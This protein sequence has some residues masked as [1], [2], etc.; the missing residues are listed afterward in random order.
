MIEL[1]PGNCLSQARYFYLLSFLKCP[2]CKKPSELQI[3]RTMENNPKMICECCCLRCKNK[4]IIIEEKI[5]PYIFA[6]LMPRGKDLTEDRINYVQDIFR[7]FKNS[8][9]R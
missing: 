9:K 8:L 7:D 1:S 6:A 3:N 2:K 4:F 5:F